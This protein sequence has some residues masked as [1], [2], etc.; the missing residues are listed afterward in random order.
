VALRIFLAVA[1]LLGPGI[2]AVPGQVG[3]ASEESASSVQQ[4]RLEAT[5]P[6]R[7]ESVPVRL[8][9]LVLPSPSTRAMP[10]TVLQMD[11]ARLSPLQV[12]VDGRGVEVRMREERR[13]FFAGEIP[14]PGGGPGGAP[15]EV[16]AQYDVL[17]GWDE[18]GKLVLP[19][20]APG[21]TPTDPGPRSF[22]ATLRIPPGM[23]V[24]STFPT[25]VL[26]RP[27]DS[28][29]G[30]ILIGLQAVPSILN[31][32]ASMAGSPGLTLERALDGFVVVTLLVMAFLGIRFI[33]RPG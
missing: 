23:R 25:S 16:V 9:F 18:G 8:E 20:V 13:R 15:V 19:V 26:S 11:P 3:Q 5:I 27:R 10:V 2:D 17:D 29:G 7:R 14:L 30:E 6:D 28:E 32:R 31:L 4:A 12:S 1:G 24:A 21:W 33:R 22:V